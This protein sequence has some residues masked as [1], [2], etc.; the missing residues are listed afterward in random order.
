MN[1]SPQRALDGAWR[2]GPGLLH[3]GHDPLGAARAELAGLLA[4]ATS[5]DLLVLAGGGLGWHAEAILAGDDA[6]QLVVYEPDGNM[7]ECMATYGPDIE[8][9]EVAVDEES[10][11]EMLAR[12]LVYGRV[13]RTAVYSPPAYRAADPSLAQS[14]KAL[15]KAVSQ[16]GAVDRATKAEKNLVWL[17]NLATN[18]MYVLEL[19]DLTGLAGKLASMPCLVVGAG[20]SL[21]Q[22]LPI[23]ERYADKALII[24]AASALTPLR[25]VGVHPKMAV[26]LEARDESR[27][28]EGAAAEKTIL[29]A[30]SAS[31]PNHFTKW[32]GPG[33]IYHLQPWMASLIGS[34]H[35]VPSGG[36]AGSA[37]FSLAI[38]WGCSPIYLVGQDL[39]YTND[40]FHAGGRPGG[41][42]YDRPQTHQVPAINGGTV[43]TSS[44]WQSYIGWY[45]EAVAYLN[46]I[47][48]MGRVINATAAGA[49]I[50]GMDHAD[51]AGGMA[52]LQ[53]VNL[54]D[55]ILVGLAKAIKVPTRKNLRRRVAQYVSEVSDAKQLLDRLGIAGVRSQFAPTHAVNWILDTVSEQDESTEAMFKLKQLDKCIRAMEEVLYV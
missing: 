2:L 4:K 27:Q 35:V 43:P 26:A 39:A 33:S 42:D 30:A 22:S 51:L 46:R 11:A 9:L 3:P 14:V 52:K 24:G 44:E 53:P 15:I 6:P 10:L 29:A 54:P 49:L 36:H 28:F 7:R 55:D 37:A 31:N 1:L 20:P 34:G 25:S 23:I 48:Q 41:E 32:G 5:R 17:E 8:G 16:R 12:H 45:Q 50:P 38:L 19:P 47:G 13:E 21:D 18:F 40:R